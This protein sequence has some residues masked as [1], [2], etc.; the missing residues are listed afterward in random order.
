MNR[1]NM[2]LDQTIE[3][4]VRMYHA[5]DELR[6]DVLP[7]NPRLFAVMAEGPLDLIRQFQGEIESY[8]GAAAIEE[9][10]ADICL[11][12]EGPTLAWPEAPVS[13]LTAVLDA[14]RKGIQ[15]VAEFLGSGRLASRPTEE[16]RRACDLLVVAFQPG[17]LRIALRLP[18][19]AAADSA[20]DDSNMLPRAI[21]T[22]TLFPEEPPRATDTTHD[23]PPLLG[24][25]VS[26]IADESP[27]ESVGTRVSLAS[28]A[29]RALAEYLDVAAWVDSGEDLS[30]LQERFPDPDHLRL[31]LNALKTLIPRPRGTI[32]SV[33]ITG[34]GM[35]GSR[36]PIRLTRA[37]HA[38][39]DQAIDRVVV[40]QVEE[41]FGVVREIDLDDLSFTLRNLEGI[42]Q[43]A[44]AFDDSLLEP[45][46]DALDK[47]VKVTGV[48]QVQGGRRSAG[49]LRVTRFDVLEDASQPGPELPSPARRALGDDRGG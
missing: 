18:D 4:L 9:T 33:E 35:S 48:R 11:G 43:I 6:R 31:L 13:V 34:P 28:F 30:Q 36:P 25:V 8:L 21:R 12:L 7:K 16:L 19:G 14:L 22:A 47:P 29:R 40:E 45:A 20:D 27:R 46:K 38:R 26:Q 32:E 23:P 44:C 5:L 17:S 42:E 41:H 10:Q 37:L 49:K 15:A 1:D 3:Q 24:R 2:H 39:L